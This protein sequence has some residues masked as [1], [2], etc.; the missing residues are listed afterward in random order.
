MTFTSSDTSLT[1][2]LN[3]CFTNPTQCNSIRFIR[4]T[5]I[6]VRRT[7]CTHEFVFLC[8]VFFPLFPVRVL[9]LLLF[10]NY[11]LQIV[12]SML[13]APCHVLVEEEIEIA[14][15]F[16]NPSIFM[17]WIHAIITLVLYFE[18]HSNNTSRHIIWISCMRRIYSIHSSYTLDFIRRVCISVF[19]L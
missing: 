4:L 9:F 8:N 1:A 2:L 19:C 16:L 13:H 17:R 11:V 18:R 5:L 14:Y 6:F 15:L 3:F 7:N 12:C 10:V